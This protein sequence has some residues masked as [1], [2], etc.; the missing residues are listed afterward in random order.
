MAPLMPYLLC[1]DLLFM[2]KK[3]YRGIAIGFLEYQDMGMYLDAIACAHHF[4]YWPRMPKTETPWGI[5]L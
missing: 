5:R 1:D 2:L 4:R 3:G